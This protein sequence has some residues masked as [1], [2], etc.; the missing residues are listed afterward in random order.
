[1]SYLLGHLPSPDN[2]FDVDPILLTELAGKDAEKWMDMQK[3]CE[4]KQRTLCSLRVEVGGTGRVVHLAVLLPLRY[5]G[6][7]GRHCERPAS[8]SHGMGSV[9]ALPVSV[10]AICPRTF[11]SILTPDQSFFDTNSSGSPAMLVQ[12]ITT[13]RDDAHFLISTVW[14][15][16]SSSLPCLA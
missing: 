1:M 5:R 3:L 6:L 9:V 12:R 11:K 8:G 4:M 14:A 13:D 10:S 7:Q 15:N 16:P 2:D